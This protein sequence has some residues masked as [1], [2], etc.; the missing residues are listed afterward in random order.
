MRRLLYRFFREGIKITRLSVF[1]CQC[2]LCEKELVL[3]GEDMICRECQEKVS[4]P[5]D[6]PF[7]CQHCGRLM[8]TRYDR[9]GECL[10]NPPPFRKHISYGRYE[11]ELKELLLKFKYGGVEPLKHLLAGYYIKVFEKEIEES[12]AFDFIVPVPP[13]KGRKREFNPVMEIARILSK[14]LGIQLLPRH[15]VK[16][17]KTLP[18]AGLTR[19][20]RLNNLDSAFKLM[21]TSPSIKGKRILLIDDVYTTGT[22]IKKCTELFIKQ[23]A[24][25]VALTLARSV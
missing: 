7:V 6:T 19:S 25:V 24:E 8:G 21:D 5:G 14:Q 10:I 18:Q 9:C 4:K 16:V 20:R 15:L 13:D 2:K 11:E 23:D 1:L 12:A 17:K 22:T 3:E